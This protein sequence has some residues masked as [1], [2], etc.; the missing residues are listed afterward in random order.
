MELKDKEAFIAQYW[1]QKVGR[2]TKPDLGI[3]A[4]NVN[5]IKYVDYLEL[6]SLDDISDEDAAIISMIYDPEQ[7][8][9]HELHVS[10]G[11][12]IIINRYFTGYG[13]N[14]KAR[15]FLR[16]NGYLVDFTN[17]EGR[18][19]TT[20]ELLEDGTVKFKKKE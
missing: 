10:R 20:K 1:G 9:N 11:R 13:L 12:R 17:K 5:K 19:Y 15:D 16:A 6:K 8:L 3:W 18:T 7:S 2:H 14:G 4:I